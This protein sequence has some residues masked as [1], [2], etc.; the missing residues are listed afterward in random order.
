LSHAHMDHFDIPL[1]ENSRQIGK[2]LVVPRPHGPLRYPLAPG[3]R[4]R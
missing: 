1:L 2:G 4:G 3:A